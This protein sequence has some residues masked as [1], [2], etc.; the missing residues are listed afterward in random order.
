MSNVAGPVSR[1]PFL[2]A[3]GFYPKHHVATRASGLAKR[4]RKQWNPYRCSKITFYGFDRFL[5][6]DRLSDPTGSTR[7][8]IL[9]RCSTPLNCVRFIFKIFFL[10]NLEIGKHFRKHPSGEVNKLDSVTKLPTLS[11]IRSTYPSKGN[12]MVVYE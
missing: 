3:Y 11:G 9:R 2:S 5:C 4:A 8:V 7:F 1:L 10:V 6:T 12:V